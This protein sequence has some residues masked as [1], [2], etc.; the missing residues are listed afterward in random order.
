MNNFYIEGKII[1]EKGEFK[2][3]DIYSALGYQINF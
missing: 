3:S 1:N 2:N